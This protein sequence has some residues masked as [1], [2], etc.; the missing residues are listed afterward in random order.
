VVFVETVV[1]KLLHRVHNL[2]TMFAVETMCIVES[3][4]VQPHHRVESKSKTRSGPALE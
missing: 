2:K 4:C 3:L 1:L